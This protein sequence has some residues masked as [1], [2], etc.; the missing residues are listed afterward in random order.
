MTK[1]IQQQSANRTKVVLP[2]TIFET[3][4]ERPA[5][6]VNVKET[7]HENFY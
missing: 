5:K 1:S 4:G 6:R 3:N 7:Y 2:Y